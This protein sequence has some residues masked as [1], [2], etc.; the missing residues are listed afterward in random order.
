MYPRFI[1]KQVQAAWA[2]TPIVALNGP[3]QSGKT[4]LAKKFSGPDIPYFTLDDI[5]TLNTAKADPVG[6]IRTLDR[7]IIDEVQRVPE[8]LLALKKSVDDDRRPGRFFL[9]GSAH[10]LTL[11]SIPESLAGRIEILPLYPLSRAELINAKPSTFID[12]L[13][14]GIVPKPIEKLIGDQLLE[15]VLSGGYPE[16]LTRPSEKR[17][18]DWCRAYIAAIMT[19]DIK[20]IARI[21]KVAFIPKLLEILAQ[22]SSQL[23]NLTEIGSQIGLD[24]KTVDRYV[25]VLKQLFLVDELRPWFGNDLKRIIKTPKYHFLDTGLLAAESG[26]SLLGLKSD[27]T[28]VGPLFET[29][30]YSELLKQSTWSE[31]SVNFFHYRDRNQSEIDFIVENKRQEIIGIEVKATA[32]VRNSDFDGLRKLAQSLPAGKFK[33]GVILYDGEQILPFGTNLYAAPFSCLWS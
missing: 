25:G 22:Y 27:R 9:T 5:T 23:T 2:D 32:T 30:V 11:S 28:P 31:Q 8:L 6:F 14:Q 17:R 16:V 1:E 19:K 3:R 33:C 26:L 10:L 21:D 7:A 13:F 29:F 15:M 4:T 12:D 18:H 20:E 24:R